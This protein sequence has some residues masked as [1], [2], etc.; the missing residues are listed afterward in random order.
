MKTK[1]F[2]TQ[3]AYLARPLCKLLEFHCSLYIIIVAIPCPPTLT[4]DDHFAV[5]GHLRDLGNEQLLEVGGALGLRYARMK[6][7]T[8]LMSEMV[9]AWLNGEDDVL[10]ISGP[11]SWASL[12]KALHDVGLNG[13]ALAINAGTCATASYNIKFSLVWG[14]MSALVFLSYHCSCFTDWNWVTIITLGS[15]CGAYLDYRLWRLWLKFHIPCLKLSLVS[16]CTHAPEEQSKRNLASLWVHNLHPKS[17]WFPALLNAVALCKTTH[18]CV[19]VQCLW[20]LAIL[21][22]KE[23]HEIHNCTQTYW[24]CAEASITLPH[25]WGKWTA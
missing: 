16:I 20:P 17:L 15:S 13:V 24:A 8:S 4:T 6:R 25:V 10:T 1:A 3:L 14:S 7:M 11:P 2:S 23:C 12:I 18:K 21:S 22:R 19:P 5:M 9:A